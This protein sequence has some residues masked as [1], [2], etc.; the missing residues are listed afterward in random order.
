MWGGAWFVVLLA[1]FSYG[2]IENTIFCD[3]TAYCVIWL[4]IDCEKKGKYIYKKN[5]G[6]KG[7]KKVGNPKLFQNGLLTNKKHL[8][9]P[10]ILNESPQTVLKITGTARQ[11]VSSYFTRKT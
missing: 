2:D 8:K 5:K 11:V 3:F 1:Q 7:T 9:F 4:G 10:R 6:V